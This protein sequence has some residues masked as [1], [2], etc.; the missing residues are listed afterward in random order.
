MIRKTQ[1]FRKIPKWDTSAKKGT[2]ATDVT[3][4]RVQFLISLSVKDCTPGSPRRKIGVTTLKGTDFRAFH[5]KPAKPRKFEPAKYDI[6]EF[7]KNPKGNER[8]LY[9]KGQS[10]E[11]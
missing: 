3:L 1:G 10:R 2:G 11:N 6:L 7:F 5:E 8:N 9:E 4:V